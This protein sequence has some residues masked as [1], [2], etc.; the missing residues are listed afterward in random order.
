MDFDQQIGNKIRQK[1]KQMDKTLSELSKELGVSLPQLQKYE[2]G[3]TKVSPKHMFDL[4]NLLAV[5]PSYFFEGL[6]SDTTT[7]DKFIGENT[8]RPFRILVVEDDPADACLTQSAL[9]NTPHRVITYELRDPHTVL[10]ALNHRSFPDA[11][12]FPDLIFL[13]LHM[14]QLTGLDLL[15]R[16]KRTP[17]LSHI[18]VIILTNAIN[19]DDM[20]RAYENH[21]S[22]YICKSFKVEEYQEKLAK[23]LDYWVSATALPGKN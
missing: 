19:R 2:T 16:I 7:Q 12:M 5:K 6:S 3:A 11:F 13:D 8:K 18:P 17:T 9:M 23:T 1:R 4:S 22:G 20:V 14:P 10:P 15:K 21:A